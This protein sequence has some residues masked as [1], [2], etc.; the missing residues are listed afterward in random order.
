MEECD[1][2][3][4]RH[5]WK[6]FI[7]QGAKVLI[8]GTFPPGNHRWS[9]DFYYPNRTNDFWYMIGLIFFN[10]RNALYCK[11]SRTFDLGAI[12]SLL[13]ERHIALNDTAR[14]VR[15]L[16]GNA[17]DKFLE[18]VTPVPLYELL[19]MMPE[20]HTVA[21]TG[22][23]AAGVIADIT[24]TPLPKMGEHVLSSDG[25]EIWRMPSTSRAYPMKLEYKAAY[26]ADLFR[27]AG[28]L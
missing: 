26:Y 3:I 22:E 10:D 1:M 15:R 8:M 6:P 16:K 27:A 9:M 14:E 21:T 11:E 25:I 28:I 2:P 5:P 4:E 12:K 13:T 17:S 24:G 23:K 18:I 19:R 7:P 20:C